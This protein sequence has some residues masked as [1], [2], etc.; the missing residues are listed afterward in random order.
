[1]TEYPAVPGRFGRRTLLRGAGAALL[2]G[3]LLAACGGGAADDG[4]GDD[5]SAKDP[6]LS[7]AAPPGVIDKKP[8]AGTAKPVRY[9]TLRTFSRGTGIAVKWHEEI[10]DAE[11]YFARNAGNFKARKWIDRD[12]VILPGWLAA[13]AVTAKLAQKLDHVAITEIRN[14][15]EPFQSSLVDPQRDYTLP[16]VA[17]ITGI[18]YDSDAVDEPVVTVE[19]L[20]TRSSLKGKVTASTSMRETLGL[21]IAQDGADPSA[22]TS[23]DVSRA[24]AA[25]EKAVRKKQ[26]QRFAGPEYVG[27]LISGRS[28]AAIASSLDV[29]KLKAAKPSVKFVVPAA[30][31]LLW[32]QDAFVPK[33]ARHQ[34]NVETLL[35]NFYGTRFAA[36]FAVSL[37]HVSTVAGSREEAMDI[38]PS[39]A[40]NPL[41]FPDAA[42][43]AKLSQF[44]QVDEK[45]SA[46]YAAAYHGVIAD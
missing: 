13:H 33:G 7:V 42:L 5:Q 2:A 44:V 37:Q 17:G 15:A 25:L 35:R 3:P 19:A 4:K 39:V 9:T 43:L 21:I 24:L 26:F 12:L 38:K 22:A 11:Q 6:L 29:P 27:D 36:Q 41:V 45:T 34:T 46:T 20:L 30:G 8:P 1:V 10:G 23:A 18:A 14:L 40:S 16:W 28:V 31:G 32:T